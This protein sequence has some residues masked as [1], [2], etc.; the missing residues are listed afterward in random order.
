MR[1][2]SCAREK[3]FGRGFQKVAIIVYDEAQIL[4]QAALDDMI[5]A[6]N[7]HPN[8]LVF[9][10][11]TPPKPADPSDVFLNMRHEAVS[12]ESTDY[13][14]IEFSADENAD[15]AVGVDFAR[16]SRRSVVVTNRASDGGSRLEV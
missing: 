16:A 15:P 5:P 13:L 10:I 2:P 6:T 9:F 4:T 1:A 3:G 7:T 11:G 12:G 14:Y 8:P